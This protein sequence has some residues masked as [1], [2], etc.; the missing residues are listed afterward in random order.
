MPKRPACPICG[1]TTWGTKHACPPLWL[2][3]RKGDA[4]PPVT[5]EIYASGPR[6]A[7]KTFVRRHIPHALVIVMCVCD[8][9]RLAPCSSAMVYE[10]VVRRAIYYDAYYA[11]NAPGTVENIPR[12]NTQFYT[13]PACSK[14]SAMEE[15]FELGDGTCVTCEHCGRASEIAFR[16]L[17]LEES[18]A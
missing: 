18:D 1:F 6:E 10:V 11:A 15:L 13:C 12:S 17:P 3:W 5:W 14:S 2:V 16:P 8:S 4:D 7:A 9:R